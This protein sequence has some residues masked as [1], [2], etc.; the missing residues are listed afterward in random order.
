MLVW[1]SAFFVLLKMVLN[2]ISNVNLKIWSLS[3][4]PKEVY[5]NP[6]AAVGSFGQYKMMQAIWEMTET[7]GHWY[8]FVSAQNEPSIEYQHDRV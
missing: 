8:S 2:R 6:Y 5:L 4:V 1:M 3:D 7:L